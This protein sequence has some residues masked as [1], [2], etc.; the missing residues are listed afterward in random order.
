[1]SHEITKV[2]GVTKVKIEEAFVYLFPLAIIA[3][4]NSSGAFVVR[5]I[6]IDGKDQTFNYDNLTE[7]YGA[8]TIE[9]YVDELA[10]RKFYFRASETPPE[11][12]IQTDGPDIVASDELAV[13]LDAF[14]VGDVLTVNA[15]KDGFDVGTILPQHFYADSRDYNRPSQT[16]EGLINNT[17]TLEDYLTLIFTPSRTGSYQI[18]GSFQWSFDATNEDFI[19]EVGL[20]LGPAK[21]GDVMQM[22]TI[23]PSD[24]GGG[25]I[26]LNTL[27]G[28]VIGP[29]DNTGTNQLQETGYS[30]EFDLL[31]ATEYEVRI[32]WASGAA[33]DEAAIHTGNI[34]VTQ[35]S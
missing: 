4:Y 31:A 14:Q 22:V 26:A 8:S 35:K 11:P 12:A 33:G 7:T 2:N 27:S 29:D 19:A 9:E 3:A 23:E 15:T 25:G 16:T 13:I 1:M 21:I 32:S 34:S 6:E 20:Y 24:S 10:I 5:Q 28:G 18:E 17:E 30:R